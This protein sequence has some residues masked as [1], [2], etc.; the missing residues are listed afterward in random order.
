MAL[1]VSQ[2]DINEVKS[3]LG[4][5][6][7]EELDWGCESDDYVKKYV[8]PRVIRTYYTYYP[9]KF[10]KSITVSNGFFKIDYPDSE[11]ADQNEDWSIYAVYRHFFNYKANIQDNFASPFFL[12]TQIVGNSKVANMLRGDISEAFSRM[13]TEESIVGQN[14]AVRV[15]D[16]PQYR[17]V[18]GSTNTPGNLSIQFATKSD[19][20][21]H[22]Q[23][24]H[25]EDALKLGKAY[26][27]ESAHNLREQVKIQSKV[28]INSQA[29]LPTAEKWEREVIEKWK[30]TVHAIVTKPA[31]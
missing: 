4:Y 28:E 13:S 14:A 22:I 23:Y 11:V 3:S 17:K 2:S 26:L 9:I 24:V 5:P 10:D 8:L 1:R 18:E 15:E 27:L 19:N 6:L 31:G 30:S 21:D 7:V 29:F 20:F 16:Y 12:Q 25:K